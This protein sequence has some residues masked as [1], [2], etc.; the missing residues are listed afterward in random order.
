MA[1]RRR[2][3][4]FLAGAFFLGFPGV[5]NAQDDRCEQYLRYE[6]ELEVYGMNLGYRLCQCSEMSESDIVRLD[7][8]DRLAEEREIALLLVR[9]KARQLFLMDGGPEAMREVL[10]AAE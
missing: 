3:L 1:D 6:A 5:V 10:E 9:A 4:P 8:F 2:A 7:C